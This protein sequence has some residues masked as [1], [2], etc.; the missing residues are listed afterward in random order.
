MQNPARSPCNKVLQKHRLCNRQTGQNGPKTGEKLLASPEGLCKYHKIRG[1]YRGNFEKPEFN[2]GLNVST[3]L[4]YNRPY[5]FLTCKCETKNLRNRAE[6]PI[7]IVKR[8]ERPLLQIYVR[9][10][11]E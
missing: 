1:K 3:V 9:R 5:Q 10:K 8:E 6:G 11:Q 7:T 2:L 4:Y